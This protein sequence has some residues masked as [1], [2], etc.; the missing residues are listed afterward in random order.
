MSR[1]HDRCG[2]EQHEPV[3]REALALVIKAKLEA[4]AAGIVEFDQEFL[5]HLVLPGGGTVYEHVGSGVSQAIETGNVPPLLPK[6]ITERA[7]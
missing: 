1:S 7:E 6:A 5:A 4:V 2:K 3:R